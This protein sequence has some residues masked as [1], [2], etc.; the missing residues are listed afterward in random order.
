[1]ATINVTV[2]AHGVGSRQDLP[3]PFW[4]A[5]VGAA[6]ALVV[7]FVALAFLWREPRL[8]GADAGRP[9]RPFRWLLLCLVTSSVWCSL[10]IVRS[11]SSHGDKPL[12]DRSPCSC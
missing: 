5:L 2:V 3:I 10:M 1:M 12:Q 7:S 8:R 9:S 11:G 4:A 6:V